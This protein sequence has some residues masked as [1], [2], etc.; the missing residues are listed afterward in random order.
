LW[1]NNSPK[2]P[3]DQFESWDIIDAFEKNSECR[4]V[5]NRLAQRARDRAAHNPQRK[6]TTDFQCLPDTIDPRGPRGR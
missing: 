2:D 6:L 1:Q 3:K 5:L 4:D